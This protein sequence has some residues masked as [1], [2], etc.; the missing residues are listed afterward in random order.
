MAVDDVEF[1]RLCDALS[2]DEFDSQFVKVQKAVDSEFIH[3][4]Q[5]GGLDPHVPF[6]PFLMVAQLSLIHI[7]EPTRLG[8][9]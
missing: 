9:I 8:M 7:S 4:Q 5:L 2:V 3:R 1:A 6:K